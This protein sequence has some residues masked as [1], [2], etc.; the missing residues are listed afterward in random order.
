MKT[1][2]VSS[3]QPTPNKPQSTSKAKEKGK[4]PKEFEEVLH[5]SGGKTGMAKKK[6]F[7]QLTKRGAGDSHAPNIHKA[8]GL[9]PFNPDPK[10]VDPNAMNSKPI[11]AKKFSM[12]ATSEPR[13]ETKAK[14][15][16]EEAN[17]SNAIANPPMNAPSQVQSEAS[18]TAVQNPGLNINEIQSIVNKVQVGINE[19]GLPECRFQ[20]ETKNLGTLDL[21]VSADKD[22]ISIE[23]VTEDANAQN[24]L[25]QNLKE[26]QQMLQDKGLMLAET[27]FT[28]RDQQD[29]DQQQ[30]SG[31]QDDAYPPASPTGPKRNF[32][33]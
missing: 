8:G 30:S 13:L 22:R 29:S 27:K 17:V 14:R 18:T 24:I 19:K 3:N 2:G 7:P 28:P 32:S 15:T 1:S 10:A 31:D 33:L 25:E 23:F 16:G 21:N 9:K 11:D 20:I 5:E 6:A 12:D 26:L 4:T